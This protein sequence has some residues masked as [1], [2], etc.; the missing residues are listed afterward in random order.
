VDLIS[1]G[2]FAKR[3]QLSPKALRL[4]DKLGLFQPVRVDPDTGYRFYE[5]GQLEQARLVAA[6]RQLQVPLAEI[7]AILALEPQAA[8]ARINAYWTAVEA[9]HT[10][11]REL[12]LY[13]VDLI[14]GK[15]PVMYEVNTREIPSRSLL[16]LKRNVEGEDGAWAFGKEFVAALRKHSLPRMD[17]RAGAAFCIYWGEVSEDS[18][19]PI[20]WCRPI[21]DELAR[22]LAAE[23]PELHLRTEPAHREVFVNLG[24]GGQTSPAQWKLVMESLHAWAVDNTAD[25]SDL[26]ARVT[27]LAEGPRTQTSVPDCDFAVPIG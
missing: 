23:I 15:R 22:E 9:E 5:A 24:P 26:G 20:E 8:A 1:I 6:L 25:P 16:C 19:G 12:A 3:S 13:L 2:E 21:P 11:R 14:N 10:A 7:D 17:G 18:D 4:Y 27:Y